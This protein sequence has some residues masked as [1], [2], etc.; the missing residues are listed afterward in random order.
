[1][2]ESSND[3]IICNFTCRYGCLNITVSHVSMSIRNSIA[4]NESSNQ[5]SPHHLFTWVLTCFWWNEGVCFKSFEDCIWNYIYIFNV[6]VTNPPSFDWQVKVGAVCSL[7]PSLQWAWLSWHG[8]WRRDYNDHCISSRRYQRYWLYIRHIHIQA[9][10]PFQIQ[11]SDASDVH[12]TIYSIRMDWSSFSN[13]FMYTI[14]RSHLADHYFGSVLSCTQS[15]ELA[16]RVSSIHIFFHFLF[17]MLFQT[18]SL[19]HPLHFCW[20]F[21]SLSLSYVMY[22]VGW[23][24]LLSDLPRV[25]VLDPHDPPLRLPA[26]LLHKVSS[27]FPAMQD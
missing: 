3:Y 17:M 11:V 1:M 15:D 8:M 27:G 22:T 13:S 16:E 5:W 18:F 24:S 26:S 2:F 7:P 25:S 19:S 10:N 4:Q 6:L 21:H 20:P 12:D 23:A 14:H 9:S